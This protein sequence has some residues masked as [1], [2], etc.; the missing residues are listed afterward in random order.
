MRLFG[1]F[2]ELGVFSQPYIHNKTW[3]TLFEPWFSLKCVPKGHPIL[4]QYKVPQ[5]DWKQQ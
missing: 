1:V 3:N 2:S 5:D 4:I